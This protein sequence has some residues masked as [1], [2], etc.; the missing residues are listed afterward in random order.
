[1]CF[2]N[3]LGLNIIVHVAK[4]LSLAFMD[5]RTSL[6]VHDLWLALGFILSV[7]RETFILTTLY[8]ISGHIFF[9]LL[10]RNIGVA[11]PFL[12]CFI[13]GTISI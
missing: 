9:I 6:L 8:F 12:D 13:I 7:S 4:M 3:I 11:N 2:R 10:N 5:I 1:M